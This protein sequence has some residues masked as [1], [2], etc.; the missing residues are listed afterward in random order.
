MIQLGRT[1]N[2]KLGDGDTSQFDL[3]GGSFGTGGEIVRFGGGYGARF[4][5]N[6]KD[7]ILRAAAASG[8][9]GGAG[10]GITGGG[11]SGGV[12]GGRPRPIQK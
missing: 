7:T 6:A 4:F 12:G 8:G 2:F 11:G 9:A 5:P 1:V 3:L 10:G